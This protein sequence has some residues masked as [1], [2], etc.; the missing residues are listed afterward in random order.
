MAPTMLVASVVSAVVGN[1]LP[2]PG[3]KFKDFHF[4]SY[5][6]VYPGEELLIQVEVTDKKEDSIVSIS[7]AATR[8]S[9]NV[10]VLD[11]KADVIAPIV[12]YERDNLGG[13]YLPMLLPTKNRD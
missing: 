10:L 8:I 6:R 7:L 1:V 3:S 5:G 4:E 13:G 9:D 11:G 12:K 2:G